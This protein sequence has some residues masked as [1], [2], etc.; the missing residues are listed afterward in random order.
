MSALGKSFALRRRTTRVMEF[1]EQFRIP[2]SKDKPIVPEDLRVRLRLRLIAEEFFELLDAAGIPIEKTT[3]KE[4]LFNWIECF[5]VNVNLIDF[6]DAL[7]D[8]DYVIEGTRLEF[9]INGEPLES[10]VHQANM[11]KFGGTVRSDG[12]IMKP[13]GW[14]PPDIRGLL[15]AQG[16]E[17][18]SSEIDKCLQCGAIFCQGHE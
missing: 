13:E 3:I 14:K 8:L 11:A 15:V 6:A 12:K 5:N 7:T 9:G 1:H 10:A 18:S 4:S 2:I 17:E 16:W